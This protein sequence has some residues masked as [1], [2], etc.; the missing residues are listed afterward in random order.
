MARIY[1]LNGYLLSGFVKIVL[2][3]LTVPQ[4]NRRR[5]SLQR[6]SVLSARIYLRH[7]CERLALHSIQLGGGFSFFNALLR[8]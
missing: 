2:T 8:K 1:D 4:Q 6:R 7:L 5:I 3:K